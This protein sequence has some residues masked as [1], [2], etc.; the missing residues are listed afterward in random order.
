VSLALPLSRQPLVSIL[1]VVLER[2]ERLRLCF[3][4]L[5]RNLPR[6][7]PVEVVVVLSRFD[8][9]AVAD[10][11]AAL[12]GVIFFASDAN[13]GMGG[14]MNMAR[15]LASGTYL[16]ALHDDAEI[17]PGWLESLVA[18]A[19]RNSYAGAIGSMAIRPDGLVQYAGAVLWN[20]GHTATTWAG[21]PQPL[22]GDIGEARPVD[23]CGT[24]SLLV[25][26]DAF[27]AIGGCDE[28]LYPAYYVDV[29]IALGLRGLGRYVMVEPA[30]RV[31]HFGGGSTTPRHRRFMADRN[32]VRFL[33]KWAAILPEFEPP[34]T[35]AASVI[36]SIDAALARA[37]AFAER[38]V[39]T[40]RPLATAGKPPLD[41]AEHQRRHLA[42]EDVLRRDYV[43]MLEQKLEQG[44]S[45][46]RELEGKLRAAGL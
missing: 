41:I 7:I 5:A 20:D 6:T 46:V 15:S 10:L 26:A 40:A 35:T 24:S 22:P 4:A 30:S 21:R 1:I 2:S 42:M 9:A 8:A 39:A 16:V 29:N 27:D 11:L 13:L 19:D 33:D 3:E 14:G 37:A 43:A 36:P 28:A 23:Y 17:E 44:E 12:P 18:A 31:L 38:C 32:R 25:R 34:P 45:R